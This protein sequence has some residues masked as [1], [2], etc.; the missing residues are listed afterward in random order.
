V[1]FLEVFKHLHDVLH[2]KGIDKEDNVII[3]NTPFTTICITKN[4]HYNIHTDSEDV[5]YEFFIWFGVYDTYFYFL[6]I[7]YYFVCFNLIL[8]F[9]YLICYFFSSTKDNCDNELNFYLPGVKL[10]TI[11]HIG[12]VMICKAF[13]LW[14]CTKTIEDMELFGIAL[15]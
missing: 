13:E 3:G 7:F 11:P 5:S 9:E 6:F 12:D 4:Y 15:Y 10:F 14:H 8:S 2:E 1:Q